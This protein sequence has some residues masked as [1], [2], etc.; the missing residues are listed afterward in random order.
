MKTLKYLFGLFAAILNSV[1][2]GNI[3]HFEFFS[4]KARKRAKEQGNLDRA[5][6]RATDI[7]HFDEENYEADY[8]N[9]RDNWDA[10][11]D[12]SNDLEELEDSFDEFLDGE[13]VED[14]SR[15]RQRRI[16]RR[17]ARRHGKR[18][19]VFASKRFFGA[20]GLTGKSNAGI[21]GQLTII[22]TR[23]S[24]N[25][26]FDLPIEMFNSLDS[27][28]NSP[29]VPQY[30]KNADIQMLSGYIDATITNFVYRFRQISTGFIDTVTISC[31]EVSYVKLIVGMQ[32][33]M[34]EVGGG[35]I[36]ISDVT[37]TVQFTKPFQFVEQ[38][39]LG[40]GG[41]NPVNIGSFI[42]PQNFRPDIA[43][44]LV[45]FPVDK[46]SGVIFTCA[47]IAGKPVGYQLVTTFFL[48]MS[49]VRLHNRKRA[50]YPIAKT[51]K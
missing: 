11:F 35:T 13:S 17:M 31:Q 43:D 29:L 39:I 26:P 30:I 12:A 34:L 5:D 44:I 36:Q 8:E 38:N 7:Q 19:G 32:T 16:S 24:Y 9:N 28:C 18:G 51:W 27:L 14:L 50:P 15:A 45:A 42:K 10:D 47:Y 2:S 49:V 33:D 6:K 20:K 48:N 4:A 41:N 23:N 37:Q 46:E 22:V 21:R 1:W 3:Q 25:I 40:K